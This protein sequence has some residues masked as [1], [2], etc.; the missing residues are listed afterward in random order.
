MFWFCASQNVFSTFTFEEVFSLC[1][2]PSAFFFFTTLLSSL[3]RLPLL[4]SAQPCRFILGPVPVSSV[5][6]CGCQAY[7]PALC[8]LPHPPTP[9][10]PLLPLSILFFLLMSSSITVEADFAPRFSCLH[11]SFNKVYFWC[12]FGSRTF[13]GVRPCWGARIQPGRLAKVTATLEL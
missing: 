4:T 1:Q 9:P 8:S 2:P 10:S 11:W 6:H 12:V 3:K 13:S 5:E 7:P